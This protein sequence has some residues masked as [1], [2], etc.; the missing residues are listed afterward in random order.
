MSYREWVWQQFETL[1]LILLV[2]GVLAV[3]LW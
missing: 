1:F 2:I 3:M